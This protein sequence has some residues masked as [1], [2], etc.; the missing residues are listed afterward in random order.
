LIRRRTHFKNSKPTLI[1]GRKTIIKNL[2]ANTIQKLEAK[3]AMLE[4]KLEAKKLA[5]ASMFAQPRFALNA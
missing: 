4:A 1:S 2:D 5:V 3:L